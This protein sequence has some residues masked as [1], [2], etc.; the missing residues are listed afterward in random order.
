MTASDK[1]DGPLATAR[2]ALEESVVSLVASEDYD[3]V[4]WL[5]EDFANQLLR[6]AWDHRSDLDG[7]RFRREMK[8]YIKSLAPDA[9][10]IR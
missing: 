10:G 4:D 5:P 1:P 6:I 7:A 3:D 2:V 8:A 9:G